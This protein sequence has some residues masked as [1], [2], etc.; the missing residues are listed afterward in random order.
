MPYHVYILASHRKTLYTG[1][2]SNI[3]HRLSQHALGMGSKFV[4]KYNVHRL[5]FT[6]EAPTRM[7]AVGR[8]KQ[9]KRWRRE[10]KIALIESINPHWIDLT[11]TPV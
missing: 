4:S 11:N 2:T 10:K 8:E 9:I 1:V 3:T 6:E 5:V 7:E